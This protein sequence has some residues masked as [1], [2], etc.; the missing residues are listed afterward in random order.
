MIDRY[1]AVL[2][3]LDGTLFR[4][5]RVIDGAAAAVAG[6]RAAG[7]AVRFVTNNASR[8]PAR[9][10]AHLV[11]LGID[12]SGDEVD[13]AA[14]AGARLLADLVPDGS[15]VLVVGTSALVEQVTAVG[16]RAV[17]ATGELPGPR[18]EAVIQGHTPDNTWGMLAQAGVAINGGALW[19]A[20]NTDS[21][22][23]SEHG[24]LP[25]NGSMVAALAH[26]TG[27]FP[28]VAGKPR[29]PL[30]RRSVDAAGARRPLM[31]G[32]RLDTDI[33]AAAA[34]GIDALVVLTGVC[35]PA[36]LLAA[37]A[38]QRPRYVAEA[39][40]ELARPA[41]EL[42]ITRQPGWRVDPSAGRLVLCST[43]DA[44]GDRL[45]ALRALCAAW[46]AEGEGA[47]RPVAGDS[48][49]AEEIERLFPA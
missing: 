12:A 30:T 41:A 33:A 40:A 46:W 17:V 47:V 16:L 21:T 14:Q 49:A 42:E 44:I 18:V 29:A 31:V 8:S 43:E 23:P 3:D 34:V 6:C 28:E 10:A 45:S 9:V 20:T 25:G 1:D 7:R 39:V 48:V 13:T 15:T 32:D 5:G 38:D 22:L 26:A 37:S 2:F 4:G 24:M 36:G 35:D 11:D 27:R 19:V